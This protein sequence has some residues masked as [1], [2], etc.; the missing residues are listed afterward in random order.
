MKIESKREKRKKGIPLRKKRSK[1]RSESALF[2]ISRNM[3]RK[4]KIK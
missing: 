4:K 3:A 2:R 1:K